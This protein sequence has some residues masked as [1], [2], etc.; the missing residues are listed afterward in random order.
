MIETR[1]SQ[2]FIGKTHLDSSLGLWDPTID[3]EINTESEVGC[4]EAE[5]SYRIIW[6]I[7]YKGWRI[8]II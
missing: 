3:G 2:L 6:D 5:G 7:L 8:L 4:A 1:L